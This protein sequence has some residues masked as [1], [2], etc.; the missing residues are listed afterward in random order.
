MSEQ[1]TRKATAD[2]AIERELN[3]AHSPRRPYHPPRREL[4]GRLDQV[5][6]GGSPGVTDSVG[7]PN[8]KPF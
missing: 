3:G 6:L 5:V 1:V 2:P 7:L 8:T 4:V